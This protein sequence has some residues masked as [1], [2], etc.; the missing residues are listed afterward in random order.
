MAF[1]S[2]SIA[3]YF[4]ELAKEEG[5]SLT[6]MKIQ[7]LIYFAHG[8]RLAIYDKPLINEVVEAWKFGP[9]IPSIYDEF[10]KFGSKAITS[11]AIEFDEE[12]RD[13][14]IPI[15]GEKNKKVTSLLDK[16]WE[17]YGK[18]SGVQLS[19]LTHEKGSPWDKTWGKEG[20]PF[21][22]DIKQDDIKNY[23]YKKIKK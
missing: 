15:V 12:E 2:K 4:L 20:V 10:K 11:D 18:Y 17:V 5:T 14:V 19:N 6:P 22:T 8:W 7:K 9:V 21:G 23:F 3:N 13:F 16:I 1:S